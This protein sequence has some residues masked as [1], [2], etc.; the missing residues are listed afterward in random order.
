LLERVGILAQQRGQGRVGQQ[1]AAG[2]SISISNSISNSRK[3]EISPA[4]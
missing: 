3:I 2:P 4:A 1:H